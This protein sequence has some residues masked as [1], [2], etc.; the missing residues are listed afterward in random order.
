MACTV[1][2]HTLEVLY[3]LATLAI[4][5]NGELWAFILGIHIHT[6]VSKNGF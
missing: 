2:S 6:V 1:D 3:L 5:G 4:K